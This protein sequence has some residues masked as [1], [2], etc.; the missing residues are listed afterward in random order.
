MALILQNIKLDILGK[1]RVNFQNFPEKIAKFSFN[2]SIK[3]KNFLNCNFSYFWR[4]FLNLQRPRRS[5]TGRSHPHYK[6]THRGPRFPSLSLKNSCESKLAEIEA[7]TL[8]N[9]I[10]SWPGPGNNVCPVSNSFCT[11]RNSSEVVR[12]AFEV[13]SEIL[14]RNEYCAHVYRTSAESRTPVTAARS[15]SGFWY[16]STQEERPPT[17]NQS[18]SG[19]IEKMVAV[20]ATDTRQTSSPTKE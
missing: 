5:P 16:M 14:C 1:I 18:M 19:V 2:F 4:N 15:S 6:P 11:V 10:D 9:T 7:H 3:A 8:S 13:T 12:N 20:A 17:A